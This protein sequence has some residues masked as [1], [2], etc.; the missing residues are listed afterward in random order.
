M[1][2]GVLERARTLLSPDSVR[3]D[4]LLADIQSKRA[5]A[6]LDREAA[7]ALRTRAQELHDAREAELAEAQQQRFAAFEEARLEAETA[8]TEGRHALRRLQRAAATRPHDEQAPPTDTLRDTEILAES[9]VQ[10]RQAANRYRAPQQSIVRIRE[11]DRVQV[12]SLAQEGVV[13]RLGAEEA[14]V[15]LGPLRMTRP[16]ED[17]KR[18]GGPPE[19]KSPPVRIRTSSETVPFEIDLR[20]A[21]YAD[22]EP[23]LDRYLD[24]AVRTSLPF[25]RIIHGKGSGALRKGVAEY[26]KSSPVVARFEPG[27]ASEGGDGVT[28]VHFSE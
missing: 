7:Q 14:D 25:V 3:V 10:L 4:S 16:L 12:R 2:E 8:L 27:K 28:I 5:A 11:G 26:L 15:Q 1:P 19:T 21:R 6:E 20:G 24:A 17:L 22:V 9:A 13:V 18:L 23:E